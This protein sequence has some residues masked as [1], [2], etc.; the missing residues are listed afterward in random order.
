MWVKF[1]KINNAVNL[2]GMKLGALV[3]L[4]DCVEK[5]ARITRSSVASY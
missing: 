2:S 3:K 5:I 1:H 4:K